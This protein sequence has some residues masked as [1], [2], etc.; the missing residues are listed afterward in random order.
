MA[1]INTSKGD[2]IFEI[3]NI[4]CVTLM[5]VLVLYPLV[6]IVS[7]SISDPNLVGRGEVWLYPKGLTLD[8]YKRVFR[9]ENIMVG[10]KNTLIYTICG[11]MLNLF[12]SLT[13]GYALS[14][15]TLPGRGWIKK[16]SL[17]D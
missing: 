8:G 10:Y 13:A 12:M 2:K 6:Y 14:K 9:D 16:R 11:T 17:R 5:M 7:C 1:V 15:K 3:V 4:F